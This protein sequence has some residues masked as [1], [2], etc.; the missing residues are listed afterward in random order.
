MRAEA[1]PVAPASAVRPAG[2][3]RAGGE[4]G[5][6]AAQGATQGRCRRVLVRGLDAS[7]LPE[8][9]L[10]EYPLAVQALAPPRPVLALNRLTH[11]PPPPR[12]QQPG[13]SPPTPPPPQ[14]DV[15][16]D[17]ST[18]AHT[19]LMLSF[20]ADQLPAQRTSTALGCT[21]RAVLQAPQGSDS[22]RHVVI[23]RSPAA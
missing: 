14:A 15:L 18:G 16:Y 7:V 4:G 22:S 13:Q 1:Q 2:A 10:V 21:L 20:P 17:A 9:L 19:S 6:S 5:A 8:R 3:T 11:S 12:H 23:R